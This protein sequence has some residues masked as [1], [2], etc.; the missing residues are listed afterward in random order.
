MV[1]YAN[2]NLAK[3]VREYHIPDFP[4]WKDHDAFERGFAELMRDLRR[5]A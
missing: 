2:A 5:D 4:H 3:K 1:P